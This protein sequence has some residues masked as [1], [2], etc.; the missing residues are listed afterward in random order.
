M[1][2]SRVLMP[3]SCSQPAGT[4][5]REALNHR[6]E[7]VVIWKRLAGSN[8]S[9][10]QQLTPTRC[11]RLAQLKSGHTAQTT[12]GFEAPQQQAVN[13]VLRMAATSA[14]PRPG[15]A[16]GGVAPALM[17]LRGSLKQAAGSPVVVDHRWMLPPASHEAAWRVSPTRMVHSLLTGLSCPVY[18]TPAEQPGHQRC[19]GLSS[20]HM[21]CHFLVVHYVC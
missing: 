17:G 16:Q 8:A 15:P 5:G 14:S 12:R 10:V 19:T 2:G 4:G 13:A 20:G 21:G 18:W 9:E 7:T 1:S 6:L 11:T 3:R